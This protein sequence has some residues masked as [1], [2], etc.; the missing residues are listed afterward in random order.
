M[1]QQYESSCHRLT[2][3]MKTTTGY[4]NPTTTTTTLIPPTTMATAT[5]WIQLSRSD[6]SPALSPCGFAASSCPARNS[7]EAKVPW[8]KRDQKDL[9]KVPWLKCDSKSTLDKT[10]QQKY[11]DQNDLAKV[12]WPRVT[13]LRAQNIWRFKTCS[14]VISLGVAAW[15]GIYWQLNH[16]SC[17]QKLPRVRRNYTTMHC[18]Y[19]NIVVILWQPPT[20]TIQHIVVSFKWRFGCKSRQSVCLFSDIKGFPTI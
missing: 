1:K 7:S 6:Y 14:P 16:N 17:H 4:A 13:N 10:R 18:K 12:P 2:T 3:T 19:R 9:A 11:L 15:R 8:T 5:M 20:Y